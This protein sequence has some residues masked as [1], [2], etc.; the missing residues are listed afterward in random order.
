MLMQM[1]IEYAGAE[2]LKTIEGQVLSENNAMLAL[3]IFT[4]WP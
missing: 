1:I 2:G 3:P 4:S